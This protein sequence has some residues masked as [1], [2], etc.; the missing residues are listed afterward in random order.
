M[1][2]ER[3]R[4]AETVDRPLFRETCRRFAER[5]IAPI[6]QEADREGRFPRAFFTAAAKAGLVGIAAPSE[7]GGADLGVHEE[8]ICIEEC[9]RV[10]PGLPNALIIQGVAGGIL[11]DFGTDEQKD[12]VRGAIRGE[13]ILAIAV[14]EPDAG[15][16][17]QNVK[18][19]ARRDGG[20]WV[21]DGI[22]SFITLA[23][24]A[25]V[26]VLLAQTDPA[27]GREGMSFFAV[28]RN[29]PGLSVSRIPTYANRPAPTYRVHLDS[30]R[31]PETRRVPAG[32]R[33]IMAGFNRERVLV[34]AR[35]FGHMQHAQDW[36]LDYA[37]TR[38]QFGRPIGANQSIAF[39]LAQN[40]TDIEAA[41]LLAYE[42]ADRW[43]SGCPI[44]ELIQQVSCAKLFVTQAVV[45]VTQN[46]LHI[47]GGWGLTEE[48]PAMRMA[49]DA[50]VAPVTV[51]SFEIQLRAIAKQLG[52]PCD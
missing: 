13:T 1:S 40:Q 22:K 46:A 49:L 47:A 37:R 20:D 19:A 24:E 12:L 29:S 36:A 52:L 44:G 5:E 7:V 14:T 18:T 30:V 15:N 41:R 11:H 50:L 4:P 39:M 21:L 43:D 38:H 17:V 3:R 23:G 27:R 32:F 35:W 2:S 31:V 51:G 8:A 28:D 33:H 6:W 45:R 16:D 34:S 42:A 9:A 25:D 26:L 48:L 10:N